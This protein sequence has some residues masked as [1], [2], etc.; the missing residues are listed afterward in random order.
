MTHLSTSLC[1]QAGA[2]QASSGSSLTF[3]EH[4]S[5][6]TVMM[7]RRTMT[8]ISRDR[9]TQRTLMQL[10]KNTASSLQQD[11]RIGRR[12]GLILHESGHG[13][14]KLAVMTSNLR[15]VIA[16]A[17][18]R[19]ISLGNNVDVFGAAP[20]EQALLILSRPTVSHVPASPVVTI[21][22]TRMRVSSAK[23]SQILNVRSIDLA[24]SCSELHDVDLAS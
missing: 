5:R 9:T 21:L 4:L 22:A 1:R 15:A 23:K 2:S 10:E 24:V 16:T 6:L 8:P 17:G 7:T 12:P 13:D 3:T 11:C 19:I 18:A 20:A 14:R